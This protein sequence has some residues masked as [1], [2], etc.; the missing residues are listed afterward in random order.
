MTYYFKCKAQDNYE[1]SSF[2]SII[3]HTENTKSVTAN[4]EIIEKIA[5]NTT[6]ITCQANYT[7]AQSD[8]GTAYF[9]WTKNNLSVF[10]ETNLTVT[11]GDN[12]TSTLSHLYFTKNDVIIC[13][14]YSY[15]GYEF[16]DRENTTSLTIS[17]SAPSTPTLYFNDTNTLNIIPTFNWSKSI[18]S[19]DEDAVSYIFQIF[20]STNFNTSLYLVQ[21]NSTGQNYTLT[22]PLT[23]GRYYWRVLANDTEPSNSS[24]SSNFTILIDT[25][26]P[27]ITIST[28]SEG[29]TYSGSVSALIVAVYNFSENLTDSSYC[30]YNVSLGSLIGEGIYIS[31]QVIPNCKA[32]TSFSFVVSGERLGDNYYRIDMWGNNTVNLASSSSRKFHF[33]DTS[34]GE[35]GGTGG[36]GGG[37]TFQ[38]IVM[39]IQNETAQSELEKKLLLCGNSVCDTEED[40]FSCNKDCYLDLSKILSGKQ[41]KENWF[42]T[43][44]FFGLGIFIVATIAIQTQKAKLKKRKSFMFFNKR[45]R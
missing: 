37:A 9:N 2:T 40:I 22:L 32:S 17:N 36:G 33:D 42:V 28:P 1:S 19:A 39:A 3:S 14:V 18:D 8:I 10:D 11:S 43:I 23:D 27:I 15:D 5:Y 31:N 12:T 29:Y 34:G 26:S 24:W 16:E 7:D 38:T 13:Q 45:K 6:D 30:Y 20:N 41:F 25:T 21:Q 35:S 44:V 4:P